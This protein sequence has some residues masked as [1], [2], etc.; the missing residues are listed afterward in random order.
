MSLKLGSET[1]SMVNHVMSGGSQ[2]L[3]AVG[4]GVTMLAWTDRHA[5]T[6]VKVTRT[7]VHVRRD[8]ATRV[9]KNG[10][11]ESQTYRY[12]PDAEGSVY[13]FRLTKRGWRCTKM[14]WG[15][16]IGER[17]EYVDPSF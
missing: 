14:G 17:A 16:L 12:E 15:L 10:L 4:T 13:V 6:V 9:D 5:G 1:G 8:K 11:S 2:K 3:P 7:Q